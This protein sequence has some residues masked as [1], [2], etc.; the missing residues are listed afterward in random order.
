[1]AA[2][3][4]SSRKILK[5]SLPRSAILLR[6]QARGSPSVA[7]P[8]SGIKLHWSFILFCFAYGL[9]QFAGVAQGCAAY[10]AEDAKQKAVFALLHFSNTS[11][12]EKCAVPLC[13]ALPGC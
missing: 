2:C 8:L 3:R 9:F 10:G 7:N 12:F 6:W 4:P 1:M 11:V 13:T 5:R